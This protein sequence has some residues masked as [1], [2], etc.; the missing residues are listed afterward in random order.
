MTAVAISGATVELTLTNP[1]TKDQTVTIDYTEPSATD[2]SNAVQD[3]QGNDTESL[4]STS[5]T[6][7]ST[8]DGTPPTIAVTSNASSLKA[9]ETAALTFNL[10][11]AST[12]FDASDLSVSGGS[13]SNFSSSGTS[14]TATFS[15]NTNST[16]DGVI[17]VASG[18]FTD[19]AGNTNQDGSDSNNPHV[20]H[21]YPKA[22]CCP[23]I[24]RFVPESGRDS[25]PLST[26]EASTILMLLIFLSPAALSNFSGSGST[27]TAT[28]TP[29]TNS[30]NDGVISVASDVFSDSAGN[31]NRDGSDSN[32][33]PRSPSIP[34]GPVLP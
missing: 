8:V 5:V 15:P 4:S 2:D 19:S 26:S 12:D 25:A 21:R 18:V 9:G 24:R 34:S 20:L 11:D 28:F 33:S 22:Q 32:N 13:L 17:S 27:C 6:N 31:T 23:E 30:T 3:S 10:S 7:N 1:V 29:N 16:T 14:Y